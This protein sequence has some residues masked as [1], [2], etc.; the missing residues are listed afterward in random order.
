MKTIYN[1]LKEY[2]KYTFLEQEFNEVDNVILSMLSYVDFYNIVPSID[3]GS[4]SLKEATKLFYKKHSKKEIDKNIISVR[5]ACYLIKELANTKRYKDLELLNYEY[6][7]SFDSQ[8][9]ALCIKLPNRMMYVSYEGTD[10]NISG[11]EEDFMLA[12]QFPVT[13]HKL[14]IEYLNMVSSLFGP[15]LY[16]GGHSKGGNLA[17]IAS[18]YCKGR[19]YRKIKHIYS[20]DG[21]GLRK[22]ELESIKYKKIAHKFTH[23]VPEESFIG[24]LYNS[25]DT[26]KVIKSNKKGLFQHNCINWVVENNHFKR[27]ELSS[28]SARIRQAMIRWLDKLDDEKKKE[29]TRILFS[30]LKK[31]GVTD[32]VQIKKAMISNMLKILKEMKNISRESKTLLTTTLKDLYNE[33]KV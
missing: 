23:I 15:K 14:A 25:Y 10:S 24:M 26:F 18:M 12:Y 31:A 27:G 2:G 33:W 8:F 11:W 32:L 19:V 3:C 9:G 20:N 4:I 7:I 17:L 30:I 28:S 1:Y 13:S 6:Q 22:E 5:D 16:V 29:I 21:P